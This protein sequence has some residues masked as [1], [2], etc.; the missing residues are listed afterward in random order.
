[1]NNLISEL[2]N[3]FQFNLFPYIFDIKNFL[4][5]VKDVNSAYLYG[6]IAQN[7]F[8]YGI[9]DINI[10]VLY[11]GNPGFYYQYSC[12]VKSQIE[13]ILGKYLPDYHLNITQQ[14][15][16]NLAKDANTIF[17]LKTNAIPILISKTGSDIRKRIKSYRIKDIPKVTYQNIDKYLIEYRTKNKPTLDR[18]HQFIAKKIILA[19]Y[20]KYI[21]EIGIWYPLYHDMIKELIKLDKKNSINKNE[22]TIFKKSILVLQ[23]KYKFE[24]ND[25]YF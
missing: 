5:T 25:L 24:I 9:V 6:S 2:S 23:D 22:S 1:M 17:T 8:E 21:N 13:N 12:F 18:H 3:R 14:C 10:I 16:S 11:N 20:E 15:I 19:L 7:N 4:N